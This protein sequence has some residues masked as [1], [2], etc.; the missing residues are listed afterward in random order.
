RHG[1]A[2]AG[3]PSRARPTTL[4]T[5]SAPPAHRRAR[6]GPR[7]RRKL[8]LA[9]PVG[10]VHNTDRAGPAADAGLAPSQEELPL[11]TR[12]YELAK[13]FGLKSQELLDRIQKW[14]FDVKASAFAALDDSTTD[15]V[16]D[17][18]KQGG[19][20]ADEAAPP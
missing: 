11:S 9:R 4:L 12:V 8:G 14:G 10:G 13:E 17:L 18:M 7:R 20:A 2:D 16:R 5:S 1:P 19:A 3:R 6:A 15:K